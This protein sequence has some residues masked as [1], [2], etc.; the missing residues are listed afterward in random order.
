[1]TAPPRSAR[2]FPGA[3][4]VDW[5]AVDGYNWGSARDWGWRTYADI[6]PRR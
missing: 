1:M 3:D 6:F 2:S 5:M 4:E